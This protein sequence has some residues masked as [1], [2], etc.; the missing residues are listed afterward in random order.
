MGELRSFRAGEPI[1]REGEMGDAMYVLIDGTA[2]V[3]VKV[4]SKSRSVR[5][6]RRGDVFGEMGLIRRHERTA[7]VVAVENVEVMSMD[8]RFLAR[9]KR[10]YPRIALKILT[11]IA[12]ILSDHL[13]HQTD[14]TRS[15]AA[16]L[17]ERMAPLDPHAA[18][19]RRR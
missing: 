11:N 6:V 17:E 3:R 4:G 18:T 13:Q 2:E 9:V 16:A 5:T 19:R 14:E 12:R 7:D 10:R 15:L 8:E 1:V